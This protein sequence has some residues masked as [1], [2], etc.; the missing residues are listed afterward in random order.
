MG[1]IYI[2]IYICIL[3]LL[4]PISYSLFLVGLVLE[5][6]L[7]ELVIESF[8]IHG[9]FLQPLR[10]GKPALQ[11]CCKEYVLVLLWLLLLDV[12]VGIHVAAPL[13]GVNGGRAQGS[14]QEYRIVTDGAQPHFLF[15][16]IQAHGP[17]F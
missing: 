12:F 13:G 11:Q 4:L 15:V 6:M 3:L 8:C 9:G 5:P 17:F 2:Y 1:N 10:R 14:F 7:G 16:P